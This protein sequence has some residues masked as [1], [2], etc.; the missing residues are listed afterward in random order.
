[1]N[2]DLGKEEVWD[3]IE[4]DDRPESP[5][6]F[7]AGIGIRGLSWLVRAVL[8][9]HYPEDIFPWREIQ[10]G[11]SWASEHGGTD[12]DPG[13][14]WVALLRMALDVLP[15]DPPQAGS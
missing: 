8:D 14:K 4:G 7:A 12:I 10:F 1:M 2:I 9:A 5:E 3:L 13:V 11:V 6:D 15:G